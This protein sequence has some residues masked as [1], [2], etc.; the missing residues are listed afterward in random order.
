MDCLNKI[1]NFVFL[2]Y[3][4]QRGGTGA[5]AT[6]PGQDREWKRWE[7]DGSGIDHCETGMGM[8]MTA[9]GT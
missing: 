2:S 1:S 9:A 8:G 6:G 4:L 3:W 5:K 7:R